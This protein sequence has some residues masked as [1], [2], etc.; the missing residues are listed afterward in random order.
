MREHIVMRAIRKPFVH[1]RKA[2]KEFF[3]ELSRLER[4][5]KRWSASMSKK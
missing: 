2:Y 1:D 5:V 3:S 4:K